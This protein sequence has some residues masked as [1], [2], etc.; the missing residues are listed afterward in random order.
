VAAALHFKT[1]YNSNMIH[2]AAALS[3][4]NTEMTTHDN[5]AV[6]HVPKC[7]LCRPYLEQRSL[8]DVEHS[9]VNDLLG[10]VKPK[11]DL[12]TAAQKQPQ[13]HACASSRDEALDEI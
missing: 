13:S 3:T 8:I 2:I 11:A 9:T 5:S 6:P 10:V 7:T 4:H 12:L 1:K